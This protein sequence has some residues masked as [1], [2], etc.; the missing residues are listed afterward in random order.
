MIKIIETILIVKVF[1][2]LYLIFVRNFEWLNSISTLLLALYL[3]ICNVLRHIIICDMC[4][5]MDARA[6]NQSNHPVHLFRSV[7]WSRY[8]VQPDGCQM[9]RVFI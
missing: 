4:V 1:N 5:C 2:Y 3:R 9:L 7:S 8:N 6:S